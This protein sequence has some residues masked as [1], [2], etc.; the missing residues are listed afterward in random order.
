[1]S[2]ACTATW[3]STSTDGFRKTRVTHRRPRP[4]HWSGR[5]R[6]TAFAGSGKGQH[7]FI[8]LVRVRQTRTGLRTDGHDGDRPSAADADEH[9][10]QT[11]N[12]GVSPASP[13]RGGQAA[14][15]P[16]PEQI[17]AAAQEEH[18]EEQ[19]RDLRECRRRHWHRFRPRLPTDRAGHQPRH[20]SLPRHGPQTCTPYPW[21]PNRRPPSTLGDIIPVCPLVVVGRVCGIP[22]SYAERRPF[23]PRR[24]RRASGP[25]E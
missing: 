4:S 18:R 16:A 12:R 23:H 1:M 15:L 9:P 25:A 14:R 11:P 2:T 17:R 8:V 22:H 20:G 13:L 5:E 19:R 10:C 6:S 3:R 21:R 24:A 7:G